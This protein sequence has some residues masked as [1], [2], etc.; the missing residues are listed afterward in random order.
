MPK[1]LPMVTKA[2]TTEAKLML[3]QVHTLQKSFAYEQDKYSSE[4][5]EIG[6]E[7]ETLVSAGGSARYEIK[8]LEADSKHYVAEAR[9]VVDFDGDDNFNAWTINERGELLET[10]PD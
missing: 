7:Q 2:K 8:I 9:A 5:S 6:F 1:L 3:R 4:L 10:L